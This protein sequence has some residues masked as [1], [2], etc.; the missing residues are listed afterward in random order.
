MNE[1]AFI[2]HL[3]KCFKTPKGMIGIGDDCAVIPFKKG[4]SLLMTTDALVEGIHFLR[5]EISPFE[6]GYKL[7]AVNVSDIAAMGGKPQYSF[8]TISLP[9]SISA[10]WLDEMVRGIAYAQKK[11][12]IF[13]LGGDTVGSQRDI[14]LNMT[15]MGSAKKVLCRNTAQSGDVLCVTGRLGDAGGG[16][17]LLQEGKRIKG[18][19][20]IEAHFLPEPH[21][22]EGLWLVKQKGIHAM[23]D[24]SDGLNCDLKR[25]LIASNCG[26]IIDVDSIHISKELYAVCQKKKWDAIE[27]ALTGGEDYCLLVAISEINFKK[28][29]TNFSKQFG[30][31]LFPIGYM[32]AESGKIQYRK[33]NKK[34]RLSLRDFSHWD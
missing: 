23:M 33:E 26:A 17:K 27:I 2:S 6:L 18:N 14:F 7:V 24:I 31:P 32:N 34:L 19:R 11:W 5:H 15:L 25:M 12:G 10:S 8:F 4:I 16:L 29:Q 28:I 9:K 3:K 21:L 22:E 30:R 13:L 1:D 20:L